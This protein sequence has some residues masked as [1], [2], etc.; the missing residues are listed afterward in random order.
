MNKNYKFKPRDQI[1]YQGDEF[2]LLMNIWISVIKAFIVKRNSVLES[3]KLRVVLNGLKSEKLKEQMT[4]HFLG[5]LKAINVSSLEQKLLRPRM[6]RAIVKLQRKV[7][8]FIMT[9]KHSFFFEIQ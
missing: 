8:K 1:A 7:K 2:N 5:F 4:G 6:L 3:S 9:R